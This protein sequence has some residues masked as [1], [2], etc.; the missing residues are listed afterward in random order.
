L[1]KIAV[2]AFI[3]PQIRK[4]LIKVNLYWNNCWKQP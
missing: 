4:R 1:V 3:G 2:A